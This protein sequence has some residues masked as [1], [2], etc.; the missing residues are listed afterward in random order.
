MLPRCS[1]P[2]K[3]PPKVRDGEGGGGEGAGWAPVVMLEV[4]NQARRVCV[5]A[6]MFL[7]SKKRTIIQRDDYV[8]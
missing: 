3:R 5:V 6:H 2:C 4:T 7:D 8:Q 1:R